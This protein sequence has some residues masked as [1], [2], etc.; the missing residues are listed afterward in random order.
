[1][2]PIVKTVST[3]VYGGDIDQAE[4][5]LVNLA[6]EEGDRALARIIDELPPR[7]VV[8]ILREHDS[9]KVSVISELISPQQ[10]L[11]A[12]SLEKGYKERGHAS[13]KGMINSVVFADEAKSADFIEALGSSDSGL[14]ALVDYF[15]DWHEEVEHFFLHGSFGLLEE[16]ELER[17]IASTADLDEG[18]PDDARSGQIERLSE[19]QDGDW[20]ELAWRLRCEHWDIFRVV[21]ELLRRRLRAALNRAEVAPPKRGMLPA[22]QDDDEDDVL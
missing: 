8:A 9:S 4:R 15:G 13:L 22:E 17:I 20:R 2:H 16:G 5:A 6:D 7:D 10:F 14:D 12:I 3:L 19:I 18:E 1:M 21:L 11:A